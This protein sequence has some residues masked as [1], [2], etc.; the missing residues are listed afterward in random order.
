K[1][2][3]TTR[4]SAAVLF[5]VAIASSTV[6]AASYPIWC[7]CNNNSLS[8]S[9][10]TGVYGKWDGGSCGISSQSMCLGFLSKCKLSAHCWDDQ[11]KSSACHDN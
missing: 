5:V 6:S 11:N 8:A 3:L 7:D 9:A 10:C 2:L 4:A 1:M